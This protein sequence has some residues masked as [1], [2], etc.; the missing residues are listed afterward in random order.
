M[1]ESKF[2]LPSLIMVLFFTSNLVVGLFDPY[3]IPVPKEIGIAIVI[4]GSLFFVYVLYYLRSGFFGETEPRLNV[5][6][7]EGPY[8]V[9]RHPQYLS[10]LVMILGFDL[11]FRSIIGL[12]FTLTLSLPSIVYRAKKEDTALRNKFGK[13][14]EKYAAKVGF[15]FPML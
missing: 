2:D 15:L 12:V 8:R 11:A 4:C 10:F 14:W 5:L 6:I 13:E 9:C 3:E 1:T 7:T